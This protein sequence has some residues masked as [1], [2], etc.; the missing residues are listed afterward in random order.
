MLKWNVSKILALLFLCWGIQASQAKSIKDARQEIIRS[1]MD[2]LSIPYL[3]GGTNP[4]TGLDC[5]GFVQLVFHRAGLPVPR[6]ARDQ[7]STTY[8]LDPKSV[9]PGDLIFFSM[10]NPSSR[11]VDHVGI[12][13]GKSFFVHASVSNG[14]HIDQVM[15]PYYYERIVG[16][17]KYTGF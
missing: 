8:Y 2:Y 16:I 5:S 13:V 10:K 3:W 4:Q 6:V 15:N 12:Y 1:T 11:R 7:F 14:I 17:R 9:L